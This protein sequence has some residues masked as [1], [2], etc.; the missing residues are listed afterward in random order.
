MWNEATYRV[1]YQSHE[2]ASTIGIQCIGWHERLLAKPL[3]DICPTGNASLLIVITIQ[4]IYDLQRSMPHAFLVNVEWFRPIDIIYQ[5][6]FLSMKAT[7][8]SNAIYFLNEIVISPLKCVA[9]K[10]GSVSICSLEITR[11]YGNNT[12][13]SC[14]SLNA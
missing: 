4:Q 11:S 8:E 6:R 1:Q 2:F 10:C 9:A 3:I 13:N 5:L 7:A 14:S 12:S